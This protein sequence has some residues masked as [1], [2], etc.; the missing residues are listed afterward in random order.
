M[1]YCI[2]F[3]CLISIYILFSY[4]NKLN[5]TP[6]YKVNRRFSE[7][8]NKTLNNLPGDLIQTNKKKVKLKC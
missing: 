2:L 1:R 7:T 4:I 5:K 8:L 6:V 3:L